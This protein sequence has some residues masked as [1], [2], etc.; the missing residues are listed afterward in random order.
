MGKTH[1]AEWKCEHSERVSGEN[2]PMYEKSPSDET[3]RKQSE[4]Q[5]GE[6]NHNYGKTMS[7]EQRRKRSEKLKGRV[8]TK[9]TNRKRADARRKPEYFEA[10]LFF[11]LLLPPDMPIKEK[12]K[13]LYAKYPNIKGCTIRYW[14]RQWLSGDTEQFALKS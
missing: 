6:K 1:S 8:F 5:K 13:H 11:F 10:K 14:I 7:D 12:R 2:H 3:R 4:A 9:E